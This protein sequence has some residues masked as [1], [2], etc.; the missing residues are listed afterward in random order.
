METRKNHSVSVTSSSTGSSG[1]AALEP[2]ISALSS[3]STFLRCSCSAAN[4]LELFNLPPLPLS[5]SPL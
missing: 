3:R 5:S 2:E 4:E 1:A